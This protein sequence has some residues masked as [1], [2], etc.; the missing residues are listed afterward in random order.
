MM[1]SVL[2]LML[3][4]SCSGN[5]EDGKPD[6]STEAH[7]YS[8]TI[9]GGEKFSGEVPKEV[10]GGSYNPVMFVEYNEDLGGKLLTGLLIETG[11]FQ[12]G[13]GLSMDD[14][15]QPG[16]VG[17]GP[18]LVFGDWGT[19]DKEFSISAYGEEGTAAS[20]TLEFSGKFQL[21]DEGGSVDVTG[22]LFIAAP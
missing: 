6:V 12:V 1:T 17:N 18:G 16:I 5:D 10:L 13:I 9:E 15:N 3:M 4:L 20:F 8:I 14:N 11:K 19:E 2:A 7:T 21:G 22:E